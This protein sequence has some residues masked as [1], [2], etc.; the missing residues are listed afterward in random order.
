MVA[1]AG[2][3][4]VALV[5]VLLVVAIA[6]TLAYGMVERQGFSIAHSRQM[7]AGSQARELALAGEYF[8]REALFEDW[9]DEETRNL[10]TLEE[11]WASL[12]ELD[13]ADATVE[14]H[15][16]DLD[17]RFNL[18]S[19]DGGKQATENTA[20]LK[21]LLES[22]NL[23]PELTDRWKDWIDADEDVGE[24]G[25]EDAQALL[26][27][28]PRRTANQPATHLSEFMVATGIAPEDFDALR[29]HVAVLPTPDLMVN[30]NTAN[31]LVLR[32][33]APNVSPSSV[34]ALVEGEREFTDVEELPKSIPQ[35]GEAVAVLAVQSSFFQIQSR[36]DVDG[37]RCELT[38]L[39]YRQPDTGGVTLL[40]RSFGERFAPE[41]GASGDTDVPEEF[42]SDATPEGDDSGAT[43]EDAP[44][45]EGD[46]RGR[47]PSRRG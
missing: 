4:G 37:A 21:R 1:A 19:V 20:R 23:D 43:M 38:S 36:V 44:S 32:V 3:R 7:L 18:N 13:L 10:D 26:G 9:D 33:V 14:L 41:S 42:G 16:V 5:S 34:E 28:H 24:L 47:R 29:P 15:V 12:D 39:V 6:S 45:P 30:I 17:R 40:W 8:V 35:F 31:E 25:G 46:R 27:D 11:E 2:A 22:V